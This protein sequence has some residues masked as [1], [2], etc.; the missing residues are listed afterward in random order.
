MPHC[1]SG[2]NRVSAQP[3]P[4]STS[5]SA[6]WVTSLASCTHGTS[7]PAIPRGTTTM[8]QSPTQKP[9][10][11]GS[12]TIISGTNQ[13]DVTTAP[14]RVKALTALRRHH[15]SCRT[16]LHRPLGE[17]IDLHLHHLLLH[18][19]TQPLDP[20]WALEVT[21]QVPHRATPRSSGGIIRSRA[22]IRRSGPRCPNRGNRTYRSS[23][24]ARSRQRGKTT[25]E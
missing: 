25:D 2:S 16:A 4:L 7:S 13:L 20:A 10:A 12:H 11:A 1:Q 22:R 21:R 15:P 18:H 14:S 24:E 8:K 6:C 19:R 3:T 9:K 17:A 5:S 23:S